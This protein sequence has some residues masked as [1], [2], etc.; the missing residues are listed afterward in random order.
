MQVARTH[1]LF[2][3]Y[4][5]KF[6]HQYQKVVGTQIGRLPHILNTNNVIASYIPCE[7]TQNH[8][9]K[10]TFHFIKSNGSLQHRRKDSVGRSKSESGL[11]HLQK[12]LDAFIDQTALSA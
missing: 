7:H 5:K 3:C 4:S 10:V 1:L 2:P 12:L 6:V 11:V 9:L 8:N